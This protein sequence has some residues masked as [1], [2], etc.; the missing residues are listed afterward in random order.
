MSKEVQQKCL[1]LLCVIAI[2]LGAMCAILVVGVLTRP[3][4]TR[5]QNE[6]PNL[7]LGL[8]ELKAETMI[9]DWANH[10]FVNARM[11]AQSIQSEREA[12][13][14]LEEPLTGKALYDSYV[15]D[16]IIN[17]YPDL[18]PVYIRAIIYHESRYDPNCRN[19]KTNATGLMQILPKWHTKRARNLGVTDLFDPYGNILVGCDILHEISQTYGLEYALNFY[20]GGYKYANRYKGRVSPYVKALKDIIVLEQTDRLMDIYEGGA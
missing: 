20:A 19:K 16:V 18:D 6:S 11:Q 1:K 5:N 13:K 2:L 7:D 10:Y 14:A 9:I 3:T 12:A 8:A 17:H 15:D 4:E